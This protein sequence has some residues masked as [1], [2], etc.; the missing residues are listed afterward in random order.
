MPLHV[1]GTAGHVDHG[2]SSLVLALTGTDPDR[3]A[4][5][6]RRGMTIELGFAE[7]TLPG[8]DHVGVVD[9]PGHARFVRTMVA[10][11]QGID[12][13]LLVVAADEGVMPQT[14]EHLAICELLGAR[15]AVVALT[16]SD[17]VDAEMLE[18]A[19]AE[20]TDVV[21]ATALRGAPVVPCSSVTRAGLDELAR[22]VETALAA[23]PARPDRGRPR[24]FVDRAF[25]LPG[26]G[27]VVT[28]TLEGGSLNAGEEVAVLPS[29][30]RARVRGLQ[31][32][33]GAVDHA[34]PGGRTAVNLAG[35]DREELGRGMAIVRPGSVA[36]PRR[37]DALLRADRAAPAAI[38]HGAT[39]ALHVGTAEVSARVWLL[40][41]GQLA[42]GEEG[43][44]QLTLDGRIPAV[45]GDRFVLRRPT[46]AATLG[47]GEVLDVSPRRHRRHDAGVAAA[48]GRRRGAGVRELVAEELAKHRAG[49]EV[50]V[51]ARGAGW[52]PAE[53][54]AALTALGP[55]VVTL[56]RRRLARDAWARLAARSAEIL[57]AFHA[58][59]PMAPGMPREEWRARLRLPAPVAADAVHRLRAAGAVDER[60]PDIAIPGRGR[61]V[62]PR[63]RRA[64]DS[65][66][67]LLGARGVDPPTPQE[68]RDAGATP[69]LVRLLVEEGRAVRLRDDVLVDAGAYESARTAIEAALRGGAAAT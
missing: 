15:R 48:L 68:L 25:S 69:A 60:G 20:V 50:S 11:A 10:G 18:L 8:G 58:A 19:A 55:E 62:D 61:H 2:K 47:G 53:V 42:P 37:V 38:R 45:P 27:P 67:A 7:W 3:L 17:L 59:D 41:E 6:K 9:V 22:T 16:K 43:Y 49:T 46:P 32:H 12:L 34:E 5:E 64:A 26:F 24:L 23:V 4:E 66:A 35:V 28:G 39:L 30:A 63:T 51:L 52:G 31:R 13:V 1:V 44:A 40:D 29:G 21:N 57:E 56:G 36:T 14:R 54:E 33:G 65:V